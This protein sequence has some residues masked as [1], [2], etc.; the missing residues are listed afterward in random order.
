M[1][2][3]EDREQPP[4]PPG[5]LGI[6]V[7]RVGVCGT[8]YHAIQGTQ[9]YFTYPRILGHEI[10][11][12]I[13]DKDQAASPT[14]RVGQP[15]IVRPYLECGTCIACRAGKPNCCVQLRV[16][17]V[18]SDGGLTEYLVVPE[19]HVID[20]E[21]LTWDQAVAVEFLSI[22]YHAV[23]RAQVSA[24]EWVVVVGAG[25][26]GLA[27]LAWCRLAGA[28]T[29]AVDS[30]PD[31]R[32]LAHTWAGAET[33]AS[34]DPETLRGQ[35]AMMTGGDLTPLVF[36]ATGHPSVM[37]ET[38]YL[39]AH[40]GRLVYVGLA[41]TD[42]VISDP[43]FHE[44]E[45]TILSSRNAL[46]EDFLAVRDALLHGRLS[47]EPLINDHVTLNEAPR[48]LQSPLDPKIIKRVIELS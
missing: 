28:R 27:V 2:R 14:W 23:R 1:L 18:H 39:V 3:L 45:M 36:D 17:G 29:L 5:H 11:G 10:A 6:T 4:I 37:R 26:I 43:W 8:D 12:V 21:G 22:G 7:R 38:P 35:I 44:H 47:V 9:P 19:D 15:V 33:L 46:A 30:D 41:Q 32:H 42:L 13:A 25:P 31:R 16:L 20:A 34:G 24:G 40:G 48:V